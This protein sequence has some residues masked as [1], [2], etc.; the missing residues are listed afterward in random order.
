MAKQ[1]AL[2]LGLL[3]T[4][5]L[6]FIS[7][8]IYRHADP[9][10]PEARQAPI[11]LARMVPVEPAA[12]PKTRADSFPCSCPTPHHIDEQPVITLVYPVE[13]A[14]HLPDSVLKQELINAPEAIRRIALSRINELEIPAQDF[15][16]L[17]L[18]A[19]G[20]LF[21]ACQAPAVKA[22]PVMEPES[23]NKL[24]ATPAGTTVPVSAPP[25]YHSKPDA[26]V[27]L[28]LDFNGGLI[29]DTAWNISANLDARAWS[30]DAD[31]TT[32]SE[33]EQ[34]AIRRIWQRISEDFA[35]FDINITTDPSYDPD[36]T[37]GS[38]TIGWVLFTTDTDR[39]GVEMPAHG[40]GGVAYLDVFNK[41][42]YDYANFFSPAFVYA[43]NLGPDN[44]HFM[45]EAASHEFGHNLGL[46]HHGDSSSGYYGGHEVAGGMQ[47]A[48]IMGASY[49]ADISTW[50]NGHYTEANNPTQDDIARIIEKIPFRAD[51]VSNDAATAEALVL[52]GD[53]IVDPLT[54]DYIGDDPNEG[55]IS[56]SSDVDRYTFWTAGGEVSLTATPF[57]A[58]VTQYA[59]GMNLEILLRLYDASGIMVAT[60]D[61][62][63]SRSASLT[64]H[65]DE[66]T[67]YLTVEGTGSGDPLAAPPTGFTAYGSLGMYFLSGTAPQTVP[68]TPAE[69][70]RL[71][72]FGCSENAN[73]AADD[74][75]YDKDGY[76][77]LLERALGSDP[78][79]SGCCAA[80]TR[81]I[82]EEDTSRY[83]AF[84][85][86][87]IAGGTGTT[88][89]DYSADDV[90]YTVQYTTDPLSGTWESG[91]VTEISV[92]P[93]ENGMETVH[94]RLNSSLQDQNRQFVRLAVHTAG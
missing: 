71:Q 39:N 64:T 54:H 25:V 45:A 38:N 35:P 72:Y 67:Y 33:N 60:V 74:C 61:D 1:A 76:I 6:G 48:P 2:F 49:Y 12:T 44:A 82:V 10:P 91:E 87:R 66:G 28:Y 58:E 30:K 18:G 63:E 57:I 80:P 93:G 84:T 17:H 7:L 13:E 88:G 86:Q 81:S 53:I 20:Q 94:V 26:P 52:E 3:L 77:N 9:S 56:E 90:I 23:M 43:N 68:Y 89:V 40:A 59:W 16:D 15:A 65:L 75:D 8:D 21:Y 69:E 5:V 47:W 46:S 92:T 42:Y 83:L 79:D 4:G 41:E 62:P 19:N 36:I 31:E 37:G 14:A 55:I 78:T 50:S 85:Y 32:F 29:A 27:A 70:W 34:D 51:D 24:S 11:A 73:D 22:L